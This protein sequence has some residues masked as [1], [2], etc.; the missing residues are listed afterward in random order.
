MSHIPPKNSNNQLELTN[1]QESS[2][3][4]GIGTFW[5]GSLL[6]PL[7]RACLRSMLEQGHDVTLFCHNE[8]ENVPSG[9]RVSDARDIT[10]NRFEEFFRY[11]GAEQQAAMF[12]DIFRYRMIA[13]TDLIHA[14]TDVYFLKSLDLVGDHIYCWEDEEFICNAVLR[15]PSKSP[16]LKDL[17]DFCDIPFPI[18]PF[19]S[20]TKKIRLLLLALLGHKRHVSQLAPGSLGPPALTYQLKKHRLDHYALRT[21]SLY[22]IHY[23]DLD[24]FLLPFDQVQK[25]CE[26][27]SAIHLWGS[28]LRNK[29][30]QHDKIPTNSFLAELLRKGE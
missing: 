1:A 13:K 14:D 3:P 20:L 5:R 6:G 23:N 8:V 12:S 10:G 26:T 21:N 28:R 24:S 30:N 16:A 2:K 9:V 29:L 7:E 25:Y 15:L 22:P 17:I 19:F 4:R 11:P 27:A 18:P